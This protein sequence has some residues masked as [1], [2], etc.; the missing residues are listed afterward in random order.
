[1]TPCTYATSACRQPDEA[2]A[3][4]GNSLHRSHLRNAA[5]YLPAPLQYRDRSGLG[6]SSRT[7]SPIGPAFV[8]R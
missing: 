1:M 3:E 4:D 5:C 7:C 2:A 8:G 6:R